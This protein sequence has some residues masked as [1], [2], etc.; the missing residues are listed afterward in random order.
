MSVPIVCGAALAFAV[1]VAALADPGSA[2][3]QG[4]GS[5]P[6]AAAI[7][8]YT[9]VVPTSTGGARIN[10]AQPRAGHS[11]PKKALQ[12]ISRSPE[13]GAP[14]QPL[15]LSDTANTKLRRAFL[16]GPSYGGSASAIASVATGGG[17][18]SSLGWLV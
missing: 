3:A 13:Y 5:A 1:A 2:A 4:P 16:S 15:E 14:T 17:G 7:S 18:S 6:D 9:E 8:Q 12:T 10:D 11:G